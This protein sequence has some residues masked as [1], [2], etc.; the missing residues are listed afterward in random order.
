MV[1]TAHHP[2]RVSQRVHPDHLQKRIIQA[3]IIQVRKIHIQVL[4]RKNMKCL[5]VM[6][7]KIT[8]T[9]WMTGMDVCLMDPMP[10]ITG[11]IGK[12][13]RVDI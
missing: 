10:K 7:M 11:I 5:I 1:D 12:K 13:L 3:A 2:T 8:M 6:I 9:S 4:L